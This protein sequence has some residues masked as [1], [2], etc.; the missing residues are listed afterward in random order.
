VAGI[1]LPDP[2]DPELPGGEATF[3]VP[4]LHA[5]AAI[6]L[7]D[8]FRPLPALGGFL[9]VDLIA[10]ASVVLLPSG[11]GFGGGVESFSWG[12][13]LGL[14]KE[15]F[16]LPGIAISALRRSPRMASLGS[17]AEGDS[18][19]V[20]AEPTVTSV[21]G[22]IGKDALSVGLLAGLGWDSYGGDLL[23]RAGDAVAVT[24]AFEAGRML[25]FLGASWNLLVL[26]VSVEGG[27]AAGMDTPAAY[28]GRP[29]DP[30]AGTYFGSVALRLTP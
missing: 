10:Q 20:S 23:I 5:G 15:S 6:G 19:E 11:S 4:T 18:Y 13:R 21:R 2:A 12:V 9:A 28:A 3:S 30:S 7:F 8:G 24:D 26:Q 16:T 29:S 17:V 22:T 14:V 1:S 27:W 25:Y